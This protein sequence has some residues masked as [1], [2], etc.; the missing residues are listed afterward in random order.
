[1]IMQIGLLA[2]E[3]HVPPHTLW[4]AY[5]G[6][7]LTPGEKLGIDQ[8]ASSSLG[9]YHRAEAKMQ[10]LLMEAADKKRPSRPTAPPEPD[11]DKV[12]ELEDR[13]EELKYGKP[14]SWNPDLV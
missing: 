14:G 13:Y 8:S 2:K 4:E 5:T 3:F 6:E 7:V 12:R 9:I 1:M 11:P 10:R